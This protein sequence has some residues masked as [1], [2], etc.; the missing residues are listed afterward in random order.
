MQQVGE[1]RLLVLL[2]VVQAER[3]HLQQLRRR[4]AVEQREHALVDGA[5]R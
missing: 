1:D 3:E 4:T 5:T 2:L